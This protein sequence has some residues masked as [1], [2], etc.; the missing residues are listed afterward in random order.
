MKQYE[1]N[2][3]HRTSKVFKYEFIVSKL[4]GSKYRGLISKS[5][6]L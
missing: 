2:K 5:K 6:K 1:L 3:R 4:H